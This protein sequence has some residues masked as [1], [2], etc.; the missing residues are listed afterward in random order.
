MGFRFFGDSFIT[1]EMEVKFADS[2]S[3]WKVVSQGDRN[4]AN[5]WR[6]DDP[7][8]EIYLI[9]AEFTEYSVQ[10]DDVEVLA[11]LRTPDSNLATK[12]MDATERYL[13]LYEPLIGNIPIQ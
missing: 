6:S 1:F 12:Y 11:Y 4:G 8:E 10:A 7:M 13:N 2:A 9:A 3:A 5:G